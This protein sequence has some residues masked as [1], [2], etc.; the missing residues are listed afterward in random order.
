MMPGTGTPRRARLHLYGSFAVAILLNVLPIPG[1]AEPFRPDFV[2]LALIY[3]C[4]ALPHRISVG[5]GWTLGII[6][7]LL[8][9]ALLGQHALAKSVI[10]FLAD[11]LHPQLRMFPRWQQAVSVLVLLVINQLL[12][13]WIRG[14]IGQEPGTIAY[15]TPSIVGMVLWPIAFATLR[16]LRRRGGVT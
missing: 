13:I 3:W 5:T 2:A 8:Y 11:R 15:W 10:A 6:L 16:D 7:D 4:I 9:G 12:V 14:A 1:W